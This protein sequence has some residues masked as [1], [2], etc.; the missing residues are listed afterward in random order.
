[1]IHTICLYLNHA[2]I[3]S[4][5]ERNRQLLAD[6]KILLIQ[7]KIEFEKLESERVKLRLS[8]Y[9]IST[10]HVRCNIII[11][12]LFCRFLIH[13][14]LRYCVTTTI[15]IYKS[16]HIDLFFNTNS[17]IILYVVTMYA[18]STIFWKQPLH[19]NILSKLRFWPNLWWQQ[20]RPLAG[21]V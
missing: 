9:F 19:Q 2:Y 17:K 18:S 1:M 8:S 14:K 7:N 5:S 6:K 15:I 21:H 20:A 16:I 4:L 10:K 13:Y 3:Q 12:S 11:C